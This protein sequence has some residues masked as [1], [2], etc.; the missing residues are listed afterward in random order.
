MDNPQIQQALQRLF[1]TENQRIVFWHDPEREFEEVL[2]ELDGVSLLRLDQVGALEA[3]IHLERDNPTGRFLLYAPFSELSPEHDWLLD[4]RLYSRRFRADRASILLDELGLNQQQLRSHIAARLKFLASKDRLA[5]LKKLVTPDDN[6]EDLDR[7]MPAVLVRSEQAGF[8]VILSALFQGMAEAGGLD[9]A[10]PAWEEIEKFELAEAFWQ[11]V[12]QIFGYAEDQPRLGN[13]L[14]RL[15][16]TDFAHH[17]NTPVPVALQHLVLPRTAT[18]NAVVC[19]AQ[20]RDSS[21]KGRSYEVLSDWV[22]DAIKL[23]NL[24]DALEINDLIEVMTFLEVEKHIAR[25]LRDRVMQTAEVI[26]VDEVR[27]IARRRQD[28]Y[29]ASLNLPSSLS[30]PRRALHAVYEALITAAEFF[31]LR[32]QYPAGFNYPNA[33]ALYAAYTSELYRFDQLY[34]HFCEAADLAHAEGWDVL[35]ALRDHVEAAYGI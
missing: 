26:K 5:R 27:E 19:L 11:L 2:P 35:K 21:S 29:W 14:I 9:G 28:G 34:R 30:V 6:A 15:L 22:A 8:F 13:L 4:I 1:L 16:V 23:A 18:T 32:N 12:E 20:W 10:P 7:K 25:E 31:A 3:K 17:L 33:E 24:L